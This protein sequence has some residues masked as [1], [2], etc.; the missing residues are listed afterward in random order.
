M[1]ADMEGKRLDGMSLDDAYTVDI[2]VIV[3]SLQVVDLLLVEHISKGIGLRV[4]HV[5]L[6][7]LHPLLASAL[8][9]LKGHA[10]DLLE[11]LAG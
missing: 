3:S 5:Q 9:H 4:A 10:C 2:A 1:W 7:T 11:E 6:R 8:R